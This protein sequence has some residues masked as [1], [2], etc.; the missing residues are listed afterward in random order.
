[1]ADEVNEMTAQP[2]FD[3]EKVAEFQRQ[4]ERQQNLPMAVLAGV[5]AAVVGG[6][7]WAAITLMTNYQ[8]GWMAVGV[9]FLVG[10]AVRMAGKGVTPIYG[11]IGAVCALLGCLLGNFFTATELIAQHLSV[12]EMEVISNMTPELVFEM[13]KETFSGMD[14]LFY[15]IAVYEGFKLSTRKA[16]PEELAALQMTT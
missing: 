6:G 9:G 7:L 12:S 13:M 4:L 14:L 1:M 3:L 5:T 11:V 10:Y 16:T 15:G 8:I 2:G